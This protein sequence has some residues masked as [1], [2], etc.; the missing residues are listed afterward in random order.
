[1]GIAYNMSRIIEFRQSRLQ[2]IQ[3]NDEKKGEEKGWKVKGEK[4]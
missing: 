4:K 3:E 2:A 1:M